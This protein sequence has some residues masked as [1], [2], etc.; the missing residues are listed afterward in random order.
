LI[1]V[2][3]AAS[4]PRTTAADAIRFEVS[5]EWRDHPSVRFAL[6]RL[7]TFEPANDLQIEVARTGQ[8]AHA[9]EAY[10]LTPLENT[11]R[12]EAGSP[13]GAM[14]G[15]LEI[16]DGLTRG[17]ATDEFSPR[18]VHP[19]LDVRAIKLN[20]PFMS[21]RKGESLQ[22]HQET[23][24]DIRYWRDLLNMMA[25]NR[26]NT[27]TLWSLHPFHYF[28]RPDNFPE[29]SPW[30]D[31][32]LAEWKAL[33]SEV[34]R[35]ARERN[36]NTYLV[37]WNT[38]VSPSFAEAHGVAE[39][40]IDWRHFGP[41]TDSELVKRYTREAVTQVIDEYPD[42]TGLGI[43]LGERMGDQDADQ[44]RAWLQETFFAGIEA[45]SRPIRFLYRAP[46]SA[47]HRSGGSTSVENDRKTRQ[48]IE[49]LKNVSRPVYISFKFNWSHG[50]S[51]PRLYHVHGGKLSDAYWN[52][53]PTDHQVLWT[54]RNEDFF[55]LRWGQPDF[56]RAHI[57][58]NGRKGHVGGYIIGSEAYIPALDYITRPGEHK[59][60]D[61]AFQRQWLFYSSWGRL[62]FDPETPDSLFEA[63]LSGRFPGVDAE[64]LLQA[65]KLASRTPLRFASFYKGTN[66]PSLYT[67]GH[68]S[69]FE[70]R[71]VSF[72]GVNRLIDRAVLDEDRYIS[73][74]D[75][76]AAGG[77]APPGVSSPLELASQLDAD[78]EKIERLLGLL[79]QGADTPLRLELADIEAWMHHAAFFADQLRGGVHLQRFRTVGDPARQ[80]AAV[81]ALEQ[82]AEHW[83]QL[84]RAIQR[85]NRPELPFIKDF[86]ISWTEL[87]EEARK[88]V[89]LA[90]QAVYQPGLDVRY[91]GNHE[92]VAFAV[93]EMQ[94]AYRATLE[95][96]SLPDGRVRFEIASGAEAAQQLADKY[97]VA[98]PSSTDWQTY[99]L[100]RAISR[101]GAEVFIVLASDTAGAMYGGLDLAE[102][103]RAGTL[104]NLE[105]S[106]HAPRIDRRGI[107]FNIPLDMRT[108]SY[109][110]VSF[111]GQGNI[112]VMWDMDFWTGFIDD[113][114]R[115]R[116]N[117]L[118]L[119]NLH[120]FP[121]LVKVPEFPE[122][123]LDDV[124]RST[125]PV[126]QL[127]F[128][129][130]GR[131]A[132]TEDM[133]ANHEVV[134]QMSIDDK[135][136][137][138]R[139]VMAYA[140]SRGVDVYWFTWNIFTFGAAGKHGIA[141]RDSSPEE[142]QTDDTTMRYFRASVRELIDTYPSLDGI[143]V[144]AG[145]QMVALEGRYSKESWLRATYGAG[146]ED[147]LADEPTRKFRFIHR[148]H[149][150]VPRHVTGGEE[151]SGGQ[152]IAEDWSDFEHSFELSF[153]YAQAHMF[154]HENLP[155]IKSTL[156]HLSPS[157]RTWLTVRN[158]DIYSF[159][160]GD[161]DYVR[162]FIN[163]MPGA[164][165][166]AGI[167]I[168]PDGYIWG[169]DFLSNTEGAPRQ[170]VSQRQWYL[171]ALWGR[172]AFEPGTPD[173]IFQSWLGARYPGANPREL[174]E[175]MK[176][177]S[178]VYPLVT[179]QFWR[180]L[181]FQWIPEF[182]FG[183][184]EGFRHFYTV[185]DFIDN[186]PLEGAGTVNIRS[187][188]ADG[189]PTGGLT[190]PAA[191]ADQL[192]QQADSA[193][194]LAGTIESEG[195]ENLDEFVND[196]RAMA[197]LGLY[198]SAKIDGAI[199][200]ARFDH[201]GEKKQQL[202]AISSLEQALGH[203]EAYTQEYQKRRQQPLF[204]NR[205][206]WIDLRMLRHDV[207]RD[208]AVA[209][210]RHRS[211]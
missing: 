30:S 24:R 150:A 164:D 45:A 137:F 47:N 109:S 139:E 2:L 77:R 101:D 206:R 68:L 96:N 119:W 143:G 146:V 203:W 148:T 207:A 48:Q 157:L 13:A 44:R 10:L 173:A 122:V 14:Y 39:W 32:Q 181:D 159:D 167:Y 210:R 50:H 211:D 135:I 136:R 26:F 149:Q 67:E 133:L 180:P 34:F 22:L 27:L 188:I 66:D 144:T 18:E 152:Y 162:R 116:Y 195:G 97:N 189:M 42:L 25:E 194:E 204:W 131:K 126:D 87:A 62:L 74:R 134:L 201:A 73:I 41:G 110:D 61:W 182:C 75:W 53:E 121:S 49:S 9:P 7:R 105:A 187:W 192:R 31:E 78:A 108:P 93:E 60:W 37:N 58:E 140:D 38:Y 142:R 83:D 177:A 196:V 115:Y 57:A 161:P 54:I 29:A 154:S 151:W 176:L 15:L 89:D 21:Y 165:K 35:L 155:F 138:W 168:G 118:T 11:L 171:F 95:H 191:V 65:W 80:A 69:W 85:F 127:G 107:K 81:E 163:G 120:P 179:S 51:T 129:L 103:L 76:V 8:L 99:G 17:L 147:A 79:Q 28:I 172:L 63:Q 16:A 71:G 88:D 205:H 82:A 23:M 98:K 190:S 174:F 12:V 193:L 94:A 111:A 84:A 202:A 117:T 184:R 158:D 72:I 6:D 40:S 4:W 156:P 46:L 124:W 100:R 104:E 185:D 166:V 209:K 55:V 130:N 43:T 186:T 20:L 123:A 1:A 175:A 5:D 3:F 106:D 198:Y 200:L 59:T 92:P 112:P 19:A 197:L 91:N 183:F 56:I 113:L 52:P 128:S 64:N 199:A 114:A 145:E 141:A 33:W 125:L 86:R 153:K 160:W 169:R 178:G 102:A 132:V 170:R 208:L 36:I 70:N 90:R